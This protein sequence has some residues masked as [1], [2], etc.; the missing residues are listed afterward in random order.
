MQ[1]KIMS[2]G[3]QQEE[4][5]IELGVGK[6]GQVEKPDG[7]LVEVIR[8][9]ELAPGEKQFQ[10]LQGLECT[11]NIMPKSAMSVFQMASLNGSGCGA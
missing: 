7:E 10:K 8:A 2:N 1:V 5:K 11:P 4:A 6:A 3:N 9:V